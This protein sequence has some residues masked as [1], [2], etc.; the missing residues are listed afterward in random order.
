M[1]ELILFYIFWVALPLAF[2]SLL[3]W[4]IVKHSWFQFAQDREFRIFLYITAIVLLINGIYLEPST[5]RVPKAGGG[6][7]NW[8][9]PFGAYVSFVVGWHLRNHLMLIAA[10]L[11][12]KA[13][14]SSAQQAALVE[15]I[16]N[17]QPV[18]HEVPPRPD[19]GNPYRY[20]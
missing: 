8:L 2:Y 3:F 11:A 4:A 10:I 13:W 5:W 1:S 19:D 14:R 12:I 9:G 16:A 7:E 17:D 20:S 18:I 15:T 6:M